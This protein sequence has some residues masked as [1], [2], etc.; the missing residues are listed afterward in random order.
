MRNVI[1]IIKG[2][3][4]TSKTYP[5]K[6]RSDMHIMKDYNNKDPLTIIKSD[7]LAIKGVDTI[8]RTHLEQSRRISLPQEDYIQL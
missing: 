1:F 4:T 7:I 8:I 5:K 6:I 3:N 2:L